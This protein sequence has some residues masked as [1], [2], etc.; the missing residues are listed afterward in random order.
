M[1]AESVDGS[2][3]DGRLAPLRE[4]SARHLRRL[5]LDPVPLQTSLADGDLKVRQ[6]R[7]GVLDPDLELD[8]TGL[9]LRIVGSLDDLERAADRL[10]YRELVLE[11]GAAARVDLPRETF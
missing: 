10:K 5:Q 7:D 6:I 3:R 8:H 1:L 9:E 4:D 2:R 11:A